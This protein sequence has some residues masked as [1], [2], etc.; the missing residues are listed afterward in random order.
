MQTASSIDRCPLCGKT[1]NTFLLSCNDWLPPGEQF[2]IVRCSG[3]ELVFTKGAPDEK[4]IARYYA[5]N[6]YVP[7]SVAA[8][9]KVRQKAREWMNTGKY[10]LIRRITGRS[11]GSLL[12]IGSGTGEFPGLMQRRG[13]RVLCIEPDERGVRSCREK[14]HLRVESPDTLS[15]LPSQSF[16]VIT[17]WHVLEH[18]H[19]LQ[20]VAKNIARLLKAN[21]VCLIAV[22]NYESVD[23][24]LYGK[25]WRAYDV[26]RHLYHFDIR[27]MQKLL[28]SEGLCIE[29]TQ[30][31]WLDSVYTCMES[32]SRKGESLVRALWNAVRVML[33]SSVNAKHASTILYRI[34]KERK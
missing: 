1:Q 20:K 9:G 4:D 13:W 23:A 34:R 30:P 24:K 28:A 16:D 19:E 5:S 15:S 29:G 22:P 8:R 10:R 12:D 25:H 32:S 2:D 33:L 7:L 3:C 18:V 26:P 31:V 17:L 6:A 21:G 27:S 11:A 14:Y